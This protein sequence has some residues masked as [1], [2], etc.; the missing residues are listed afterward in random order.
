LRG[1]FQEPGA[2]SQEPGV[3]EFRSS[4]V[5]EFRSSGRLALIVLVVDSLAVNRP[6]MTT[7]TRA[8]RQVPRLPTNRLRRRILERQQTEDDDDHEDD[9]IVPAE[10][11]K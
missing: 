11:S 9:Q 7:I 5:Q 2:R 6:R 10:C 3:Q 1:E 4:G 8:I